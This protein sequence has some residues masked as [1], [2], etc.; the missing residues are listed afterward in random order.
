MESDC[1]SAPCSFDKYADYAPDGR[2]PSHQT[3][4]LVCRLLPST[5][6]LTIYYPKADNHF[7]VPRTGPTDSEGEAESPTHCCSSGTEG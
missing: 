1:Q 4:R 6:T 7:T 5:A 3:S 2:Q